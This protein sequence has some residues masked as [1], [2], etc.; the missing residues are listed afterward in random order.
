MSK[1]S[2]KNFVDNLE[3]GANTE[4]QKNFNNVMADKVSASLDDAKT[5]LAKSVF[6]GEKGVE[7][8]EADPFTGA[9]IEQPAE[10][11]PA[12]EVPSNDQDAQ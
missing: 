10:E 8:P 2:L 9:N 4:A 5:D 1:E 6:T 3:K 12:E 7:A 11:T